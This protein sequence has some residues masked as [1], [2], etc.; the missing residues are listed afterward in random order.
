MLPGGGG[1][2]MAD[3]RGGLIFVSCGYLTVQEKKLGDDVCALVRELIPHD[4]YFAERQSSLEGLTKNILGSLDRAIGLVA[5][6]HPRG[7]ATY[8]DLAGQTCRQ[9]RAANRLAMG[10]QAGGSDCER[11]AG[12]SD[13]GVL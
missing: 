5:I 8:T 7:T 9:I 6:M 2:T 3:S 13:V 4:P 10:V 1:C 11:S 12:P